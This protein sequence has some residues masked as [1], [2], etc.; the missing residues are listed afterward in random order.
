MFLSA[1][2]GVGEVIQ[3]L[4]APLPGLV[5]LWEIFSKPAYYLYYVTFDYRCGVDLYLE[6]LGLKEDLM[7]QI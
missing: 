1:D 5:I 2:S 3:L 7:K 6:M 4:R